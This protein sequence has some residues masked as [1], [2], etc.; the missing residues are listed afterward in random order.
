[1]ETIPTSTVSRMMINASR[2]KIAL[3]DEYL[4]EIAKALGV[5][6]YSAKST[7]MVVNEILDNVLALRGD[8][9]G[10]DN[11]ELATPRKNMPRES[12]DSSFK[13]LAIEL[14][15]SEEETNEW[16]GFI[17]GLFEE[18]HHLQGDVDNLK[19]QL[20]E[21]KAEVKTL[22]ESKGYKTKPPRNK[23]LPIILRELKDEDVFA[24]RGML[25]R[26]VAENHEIVIADQKAELEKAHLEIS[27]LK[28]KIELI[29]PDN[30]K[31]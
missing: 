27:R 3:F 23:S 13:K 11:E 6:W 24:T 8:I 22:R 10:N 17:S 29:K 25:W 28:S 7:D 19:R 20:L 21:V 2:H 14:G 26:T 18:S 4:R 15:A 12:P 31:E 9:E 16:F 30:D 5:K 1:M